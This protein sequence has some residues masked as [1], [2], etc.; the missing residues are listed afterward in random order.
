[1]NK[2]NKQERV[3]NTYENQSFTQHGVLE[4]GRSHKVRWIGWDK[5]TEN[6]TTEC[7]LMTSEQ[8]NACDESRI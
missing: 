7:R 6:L 8:E 2:L 4:S 5:I 1:M 3:W